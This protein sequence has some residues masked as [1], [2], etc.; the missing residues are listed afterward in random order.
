MGFVTLK[1]VFRHQHGGP[2]KAS[3]NFAEPGE[4]NVGDFWVTSCRGN[5][6]CQ[7]F[8]AFKKKCQCLKDAWFV[9]RSQPRSES[10]VKTVDIFLA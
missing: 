10:V 1:A 7:G 9:L 5:G 4:A 6:L 2:A 3:H 8:V